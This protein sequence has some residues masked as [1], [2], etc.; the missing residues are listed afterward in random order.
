MKDSPPEPHRTSA[1]F[2]EWRDLEERFRRLD[3]EEPELRAES[4]GIDK[5]W[6]IRGNRG[7]GDKEFRNLA[8]RAAM[9]AGHPAADGW[10]WWLDRLKNYLEPDSKTISVTTIESWSGKP[11]AAEP[12]TEE[13]KPKDHPW[14]SAETT[15]WDAF[16]I[17]RP[18]TSSAE[19]CDERANQQL[20]AELTATNVPVAEDRIRM[21]VS[22][23]S[24]TRP[25]T[26]EILRR[27]KRTI[28][29]YIKSG[30]LVVDKG[31]RVTTASINEFLKK[32]N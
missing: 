28:C 26:A 1:S 30:K 5:V 17:E 8:T 9:Y 21:L 15:E 27:S 18:C 22:K 10:E 16:T 6:L 29:R 14:P 23:P 11:L 25:E 3:K 24:C 19:Y 32:A 2:D 31:N 20:R 12:L 13:E 4:Y 7:D